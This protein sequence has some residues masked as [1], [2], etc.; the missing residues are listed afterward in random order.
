M[1]DPGFLAWRAMKRRERRESKIKAMRR[2]YILHKIVLNKV[3][4]DEKKQKKRAFSFIKKSNLNVARILRLKFYD[5][6][7][8]EVPLSIK[9]WALEKIVTMD[10]LKY[11]EKPNLWKYSRN[12]TLLRP[13]YSQ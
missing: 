10:K 3:L 11:L 6:G 5:L 8:N 9:M 2:K 4:R 1:D 12:I 13:I 7:Y